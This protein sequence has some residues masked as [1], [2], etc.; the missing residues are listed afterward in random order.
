MSVRKDEVQRDIDH[1]TEAG[2]RSALSCLIGMDV[3]L[4]NQAVEHVQ[5]TYP[6]EVTK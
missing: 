6:D 4:V 5:E 1:L 3:H 2:C